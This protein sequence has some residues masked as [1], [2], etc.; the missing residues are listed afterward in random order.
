M[1]AAWNVTVEPDQITE[2]EGFEVAEENWESLLFFLSCDTQWRVVAGF[3]GCMW[4][5][6]DYTACEIQLRRLN[7]PEKV[8]PDL[9]RI[10]A[11]A[12]PIMNE[13]PE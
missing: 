7:A 1:A 8:W 9:M 5:G 4:I 2:E 12:L 13:R 3:G 6:L 11:A 10:E